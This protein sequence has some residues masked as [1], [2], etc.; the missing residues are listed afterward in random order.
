MQTLKVVDGV[1]VTEVMCFPRSGHHWL[2]RLLQRYLGDRFHY[3]EMYQEPEL[4]LDVCPDTNFQK[5]HDVALDASVFDHGIDLTP[6]RDD[7]KYL[8]QIRDPI[9]AFESRWLLSL[10]ENDGVLEDTE[11]CWRFHMKAWLDYYDSFVYRWIFSPVPNRMVLRYH[12]LM[13]SPVDRLR[14]VLR[15]VGVDPVDERKLLKAV[16]RFP[17]QH[18][19]HK[20]RYYYEQ[21]PHFDPTC[22]YSI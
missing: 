13:Q 2:M 6:I 20:T 12:D 14:D 4:R 19:F 17:P 7:R 22:Q 9:E 18:T 11:E 1:H 5:N 16:R 21:R 10:K 3:C 15:F 8:V